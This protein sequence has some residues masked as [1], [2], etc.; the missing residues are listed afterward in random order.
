MD[1]NAPFA[2]PLTLRLLPQ[3]NPNE[4]D[5]RIA[6]AELLNA[7]LMQQLRNF[8]QYRNHTPVADDDILQDTLLLAWIKVEQG[9]YTPRQSP[10]VAYLKAIA[11]FKIKEAA[12]QR[13]HADIDIYA[14]ALPD[15]RAETSGPDLLIADE[16]LRAALDELPARRRDVLLLSELY[17]YSGDEIATH[18]H[19]RADLVRKDKSLALQQLRR[20][21]APELSDALSSAA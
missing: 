12:R 1:V 14:E 13:Y 19:I 3:F 20:T 17:D 18:F 8:I 9:E 7:D 21:L 5:R 4:H 15:P 10:F 11:R 2:D 6:W 16:V